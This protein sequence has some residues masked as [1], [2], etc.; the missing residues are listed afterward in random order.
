M[1][2]L[3]DFR[4]DTEGKV[5]GMFYA[6]V[7]GLICKVAQK[8]C[9]GMSA[10]PSA[11][12]YHNGLFFIERV[13][14]DP[15]HVPEAPPAVVLRTFNMAEEEKII[16]EDTE[17]TCLRFWLFNQSKDLDFAVIIKNA[18]WGNEQRMNREMKK[19]Y[20]LAARINHG[21]DVEAP[22]FALEG[23][24]NSPFDD[25]SDPIAYQELVAM[26]THVN[27]DVLDISHNDMDVITGQTML[28]PMQAFSLLTNFQLTPKGSS[29]LQSHPSQ[30]Y[31]PK[32]KNGDPI[33][34][35]QNYKHLRT[36][37]VP[38]AVT[39]IPP[40]ECSNIIKLLMS[41]VPWIKPRV[42]KRQAIEDFAAS[43][44]V[45]LPRIKRKMSLLVTEDN[46]NMEKEI[47]ESKNLSVIDANYKKAIVDDHRYQLFNHAQATAEV[48]SKETDEERKMQRLRETNLVSFVKRSFEPKRSAIGDDDDDDDDDDEMSAVVE[49]KEGKAARSNRRIV[50]AAEIGLDEDEEEDDDD[51]N[52][53]ASRAAH[54]EQLA[55]SFQAPDVPK[56]DFSEL[57]PSRIIDPSQYMVR[58]GL[59]DDKTKGDEHGTY[60]T[61]LDE[62]RDNF[63]RAK[64]NIRKM[65]DSEER[66]QAE[67]ALQQEMYNLMSE[68][69]NGNTK[70]TKVHATINA[71]VD[72]HLR[73]LKRS[74]R[75]FLERR[76]ED[77]EKYQR[78][79]KEHLERIV[80]G[81]LAVGR[82]DDDDDDEE[83]LTP[84]QLKQLIDEKLKATVPVANLSVPWN[85]TISNLSVACC[86]V[87]DM[88]MDDEHIAYDQCSHIDMI[89]MWYTGTDAFRWSFGLHLNI[90]QSGNMAS[91][92]SHSQHADAHKRIVDTYEFIAHQTAQ[93]DNTH[94]EG[95]DKVRYI[96]EAP[97]KR[98]NTEGTN[99]ANDQNSSEEAR[100]K[101]QLT[102]MCNITQE[103]KRT[104]KG[105]VRIKQRSVYQCIGSWVIA[106]NS[107]GNKLSKPMGSRFIS[108]Q[109]SVKT[110]EDRELFE[111]AVLSRD[112]DP[113]YLA[114]RKEWQL[115]QARHFYLDKGIQQASIPR[116]TMFGA[117]VLLRA[118]VLRLTE[119]GIQAKSTRKYEQVFILDE[120][121]TKDY[122]GHVAHNSKLSKTINKD[123][124]PQDIFECVPY[125]FATEDLT[126]MAIGL[127][128]PSWVAPVEEQM[129]KIF[130]E[131]RDSGKLKPATVGA[132]GGGSSGNGSSTYGS[133]KNGR[134]K[135]K[136]IPNRNLSG[137]RNPFDGQ[138]AN[139]LVAQQATQVAIQT[140]K[141]DPDYWSLPYVGS[142]RDKIDEIMGRLGTEA[143]TTDDYS[144]YLDELKT[145]FVRVEEEKISEPEP[146]KPVPGL[147]AL[148]SPAPPKSGARAMGDYG[149]EGLSDEAM[150][151][152]LP[153]AEEEKKMN[154]EEKKKHAEARNNRR[155]TRSI[156]VLKEREGELLISKVYL[157]T[158]PSEKL[159]MA[160]DVFSHAHARERTVLWPRNGHPVKSAKVEGKSFTHLTLFETI[161]VTKNPDN[162]L[163]YHN[164]VAMENSVK[165]YFSTRGSDPHDT[166]NTE[167]GAQAAATT[168][169]AALFENSDATMYE[170]DCDLD[171]LS[172]Q[173]HATLN[174][175]SVDLKN[176]ATW[177]AYPPITKKKL[178]ELQEKATPGLK[179]YLYPDDFVRTSVEKHITKK[180]S[181]VLTLVKPPETVDLN[182]PEEPYFAKPKPRPKPV[183]KSKPKTIFKSLTIPNREHAY[184]FVARKQP[185]QVGYSKGVV[186]AKPSEKNYGDDPEEDDNDNDNDDGD[187]EADDE[188]L[189]QV[190]AMAEEDDEAVDGEF[191]TDSVEYES[192]M[193]SE[194][195]S[196][197]GDITHSKSIV[198]RDV[199]TTVV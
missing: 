192:N 175:R 159:L 149:D 98:F 7:H 61:V 134:G 139:A 86:M 62:I 179:T 169:F 5:S 121:M 104:P 138:D 151:G 94:G 164:A 44:G 71:F 46:E 135:M 136:S 100:F 48:S 130:T 145:R 8:I 171:L 186:L 55:Q 155:K 190:E 80:Q 148:G 195:D 4:K 165:E 21:A 156:P 14:R 59:D 198:R 2:C 43:S 27:E 144:G 60:V 79:Q 143:Y 99:N 63:N 170:I 47:I 113:V 162:K 65:V 67:D 146:P 108:M 37:P 97:P 126:I 54:Q 12:S 64:A 74:R 193:D 106:T 11:K 129:H 140:D 33:D 38:S 119:L 92:K 116:V 77:V 128:S 28:N 181:E 189:T 1:H 96:E 23:E 111:M 191:D 89:K 19:N 160:T 16:C 178:L 131:L 168:N 6:Q 107:S 173:I 188:S 10:V 117:I 83:K 176:E 185:G 125:L 133:W 73:E 32:P 22:S 199:R 196:D 127:C 56:I 123:W 102:N 141:I 39:L 154:G 124:V 18:V 109:S 68:L 172:L 105:G 81:N 70:V 17:W 166:M 24:V 36:F 51:N 132:A 87:W 50:E 167:D 184:S 49:R 93:A 85:F 95:N 15:D 42:N 174:P 137:V 197:F 122:S 112:S 161:H 91:G 9:G 35:K 58:N 152:L 66:K 3:S 147:A 180:M 177:N 82:I 53:I 57:P 163:Y 150:A 26:Y 75:L 88:V 76:G 30:Y 29:K 182:I 45:Q 153:I 115:R 118:Y 157:E 31:H 69:Y 40:S 142:R 52:P 120:G 194:S 41:P 101:A 183:P 158:S 114:Y 187:A 72:D 103:F 84:D 110:R 78:Q 90:Y 34:S 25:I 20:E 13:F